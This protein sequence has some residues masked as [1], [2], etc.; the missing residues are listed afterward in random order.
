VNQIE[1]CM[2]IFDLSVRR[3]ANGN[4]LRIVLESL[5]DLNLEKQLIE[6]RGE[7][8][9]AIITIENS[10]NPLES[11]FEIFDIKCRRL[12]NGDKLRVILEQMYDKENEIS[13]VKMR[14]EDVMIFMEKVEP[15][16]PGLQED[17]E[18]L[19]TA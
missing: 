10:N 18:N 2:E 6:F 17:E 11:V 5:E 19:L 8:V 4:K 12:R 16:L 15:D 7:N 9:K 3:L 1:F 13:L 14:G